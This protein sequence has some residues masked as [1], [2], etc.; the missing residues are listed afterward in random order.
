M[1][2]KTAR[3]CGKRGRSGSLGSISKPTGLVV[4]SLEGRQCAPAPKLAGH[5]LQM[6]LEQ[7]GACLSL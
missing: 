1:D 6:S 3:K 5:R 7:E 2:L 4:L